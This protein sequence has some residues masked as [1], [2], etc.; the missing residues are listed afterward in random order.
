MG[1]K[2]VSEENKIDESHYDA[3]TRLSER[4]RDGDNGVDGVVVVER[5][6]KKESW[7]SRESR[8]SNK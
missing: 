7:E 4:E 8:I 2:I 6:R 5:K 3:I 1:G